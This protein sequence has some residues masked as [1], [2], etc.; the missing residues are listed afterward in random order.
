MVYRE[1]DEHRHPLPL[2]LGRGRHRRGRRVAPD[3]LHALRR[4]P[5]LHA[6]R[7]R[8]ATRCSPPA[9]PRSAIEQ[10]G[11]LHASM[12]LLQVGAQAG[13][14]RAR[15]TCCSTASS[16]PGDIRT[17]DMQASPYDVTSLRPATRSRSRR[18]RARPSTS[19]GSA[20]S[21]SAANALRARLVARVRGPA[22]LTLRCRAG[23]RPPRRVGSVSA[24][25]RNGWSGV[26]T[27]RNARSCPSNWPRTFTSRSTG[28]V[29]GEDRVPIHSGPRRVGIAAPSMATCS[30]PSP[31]MSRTRVGGVVGRDVDVGT[32]QP[33]VPVPSKPKTTRS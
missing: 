29:R 20:S 3:P 7:G 31:A 12:D 10:P 2:R 32:R 15:A 27:P 11:C 13:P 24:N 1:A 18:P 23:R 4:V 6:R 19:R 30:V 5:V 21:P 22:P 17:L 28:V 9:R 33:G 25:T 16:S 14:G 8:R 26:S